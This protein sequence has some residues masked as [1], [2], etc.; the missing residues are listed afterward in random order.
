MT[1]D[2]RAVAPFDGHFR[3][4]SIAHFK[5]VAKN[6][7]WLLE[8]PVQKCQEDLAR[9]YGYSGLHELQLV[10]KKPGIPGPFAPRY[11]YL[12]S[13]QTEL[14][15][16]QERRIFF[17]LFGVLKDYRRQ[18]SLAAD[19]CFLVFEMGLFQEAAEQRVCFEKIRQVISYEVLSNDGWPLIH[20][21]PLGLKAW[22]AS[23]YTEPFEMADGWQK[24]L[25]PSRYFSAVSADM[26]LQRRMTGLVRLATMFQIL[27]P[28]IGGRK[29]NG[30]GPVAFGQ[31]E[32]EGAGITDPLWEQYYLVEW[33]SNKLPKDAEAVLR[34]QRELIKAFVKRPSRATAAPCYFVKDLKDPVGFRD[35]WAFE[36]FKAA[37][38][39]YFDKSKALFSSTLDK[40]N[41]HSLFLH[42]D[43]NSAEISESVEGQIWQLN[44]TC[45]VVADPL[46]AGRRPTLQP[47]IHANG[48]LIVPYDDELIAMAPT[49]W[50][51]CHD[52][53]DF[54]SETAALAFEYLYLPAIGVKEMDFTFK[55]DT[56]SIVEIDELLL[57]SSV[58]V[59]A[60]TV[61]FD[62][63]LGAFDDYCHPDSYGYW[64]NILS[65]GYGD[66][67]E[68]EERNE[69]SAYAYYVPRPA[70]ILI[71]VEGCGLTFVDAI[72]VNDNRVSSLKRDAKMKTTPS[73]E[74]LAAMVMEAVKELTVDVV[75][76]DSNCSFSIR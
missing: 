36:S 66:K 34:E 27:A 62:E 2:V 31:F 42:M 35:R 71:N 65:L 54:A 56:Y 5:E 67:D 24:I 16:G 28:R 38:N 64:S 51:F 30:M 43:G 63:L 33:L 26:R 76:Y 21:W 58:S 53:S 15:E 48:S 23:G 74:A 13:D 32:D 1:N 44:C 7:A 75:V 14:V 60:L 46:T 12:A 40:E 55:G 9:I 59:E 50:F 69:D 39:G 37:L 47:V 49:D 68:N 41:L 19:R 72:H 3:P 18:Y 25:P 22:L 4:E 11:N 70:V 45:S 29:P 73:G 52:D 61:F 10:L 20:G 8:R 57:A 6:M 17:I